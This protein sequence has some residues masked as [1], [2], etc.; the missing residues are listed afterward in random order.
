MPEETSPINKLLGEEFHDKSD[1]EIIA[2]L[3]KTIDFLSSNN[4]AMAHQYGFDEKF[5]EMLKV[6]LRD[7]KQACEHA[8]H[9]AI[10]ERIAKARLNALADQLLA[11]LPASSKGN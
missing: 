7:F 2:I 5:V 8:R 4:F 9:S 3:M 6:R 10:S 11:S 1:E